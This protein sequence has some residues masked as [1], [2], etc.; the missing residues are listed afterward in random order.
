MRRGPRPALGT[1]PTEGRT[2]RNRQRASTPLESTTNSNRRLV[3]NYVGF[4]WASRAHD[5]TVLDEAG[6]VL[7]RWAF[8]HS[9]TGWVTTFGPAGTA[10]IGRRGA[11]D[12]RA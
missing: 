3:M 7:D 2:M 11:G 12:H 10:R 5:V 8:P 1:C 4:D 9:E 6:R